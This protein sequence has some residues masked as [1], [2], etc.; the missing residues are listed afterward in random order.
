MQTRDWD[1]AHQ[2][3]YVQREHQGIEETSIDELG[4]T[5]NSRDDSIHYLNNNKDSMKSFYVNPP[6]DI[7][8]QKRRYKNNL[9]G[10]KFENC[11]LPIYS[12]GVSLS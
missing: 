4:T 7:N 12:L 5:T 1:T 3:R 2:P 8:E 9:E 11:F 10:M 6:K